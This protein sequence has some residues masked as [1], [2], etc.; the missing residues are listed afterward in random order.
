M[1]LQ[2]KDLRPFMELQDKAAGTVM[3]NIKEMPKQAFSGSLKK[4]ETLSRQQDHLL[5]IKW[6]DIRDV[7]L[8][9]TAH[10]S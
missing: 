4:G 9:T 6:R 2:S 5:A 3:S 10:C 1:V 7:F 8:L